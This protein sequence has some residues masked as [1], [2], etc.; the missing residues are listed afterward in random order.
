MVIGPLGSA[1]LVR[2][3]YPNEE[4]PMFVTLLGITRLVIG[5]PQKPTLAMLVTPL[6]RES[7]QVRA[8][9]ERVF[10]NGAADNINIGD[11]SM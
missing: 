5:S 4:S 7:G 8:C 1:R 2:A 11:G 3:Q 9:V 10:P 6:P